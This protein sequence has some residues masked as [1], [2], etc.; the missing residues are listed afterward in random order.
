M[1]N[2]SL[3]LLAEDLF[4][5]GNIDCGE[6]IVINGEIHGTITGRGEILVGQSGRIRGDLDG[7]TVTI[8][9]KME[10]NMFIHEQLEVAATGNVMGHIQVKP[11]RM[12]IREGALVQGDC[13]FLKEQ[14]RSA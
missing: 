6:Q 7:D 13:Q 9:G 3:G 4:L 5:E 12:I 1:N 2:K 14:D 8:A 10:G 11:G